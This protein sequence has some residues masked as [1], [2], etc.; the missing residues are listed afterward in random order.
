MISELIAPPN[1]ESWGSSTGSNGVVSLAWAK[2]FP[3]NSLKAFPSPFSASTWEVRFLPRQF[4]RPM[5][6]CGFLQPSCGLL[7]RT[8]E[9]TRCD[10]PTGVMA[11]AAWLFPEIGQVDPSAPKTERLEQL[12]ALFTHPQNGRVTRTIVNRLWAQLMGRGH[13]ASARRNGDGTGSAD[14]LDWLAYDFQKMDTTSRGP[15]V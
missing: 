14:L 1:D 4:H 3:S 5:D 7:R 11:K 13:R 9:L 15:C 6:S 12:A 8:L 10:K 2:A